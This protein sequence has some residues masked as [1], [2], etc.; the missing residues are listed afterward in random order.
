MTIDLTP[1]WLELILNALREH[2]D[3]RR[4]EGLPNFEVDELLARLKVAEREQHRS[5]GAG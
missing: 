4:A 2:A 3:R 1:E 5:P